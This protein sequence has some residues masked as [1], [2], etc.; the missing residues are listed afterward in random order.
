[1]AKPALYQFPCF[2]MSVTIAHDD[3]TE[4]ELK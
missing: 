4:H 3:K 2:Q 1:M